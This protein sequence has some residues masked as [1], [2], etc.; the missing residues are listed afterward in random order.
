MAAMP[1]ALRHRARSTRRAQDRR[2]WGSPLAVE[3]RAI[4]QW[5][6]GSHFLFRSLVVAVATL[7]P[8]IGILWATSNNPDDVVATTFWSQ[9]AT[10]LISLGVVGVFY[11]SFL[12]AAF[13]RDMQQALGLNSALLDAGLVDALR[14]SDS[15]RL[16]QHFATAKTISVFPA[17]P[18]T[19]HVQ[20]YP[21]LLPLAQERKMV[22]RIYL[23][24]ADTL[25]AS[26]GDVGGGIPGS[27]VA[28]CARTFEE[29]RTSWD[30]AGIKANGSRLERFSYVGVPHGGFLFSGDAAAILVE[31]PIGVN[32]YQSG[33]TYLYRGP[34]AK[35]TIDWLTAAIARLNAAPIDGSPSDDRDAREILPLIGRGEP[36]AADLGTEGAVG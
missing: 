5:W 14:E 13:L 19:W 4:S 20:N 32:R 1:V 30:A 28:A 23:P 11:E 3:R 31:D 6:E 22:V 2:P 34:R 24:T 8:G 27:D 16:K 18:L 9:V 10:T 36:D 35:D 21:W 12:K 15:V 17:D 26:K 7:V 25:S 33:L 29:Y